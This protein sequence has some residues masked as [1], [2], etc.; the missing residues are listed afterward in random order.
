MNPHEIFAIWND[1]GTEL[2]S[3]HISYDDADTEISNL[4]ENS[5]E[6]EVFYL[7]TYTMKVW[8]DRE[9]QIGA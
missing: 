7:V 2:I 8:E 1:D 3:T 5:D 4:L 9:T 6:E